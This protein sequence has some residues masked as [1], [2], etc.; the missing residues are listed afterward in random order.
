MHVQVVLGLCNRLRVMFS[1]LMRYPP[2]LTVTWIKDR[3]CDAH[4]QDLF[5]YGSLKNIVIFDELPGYEKRVD[6]RTFEKHPQI[7]WK[8]VGNALK[9]H[10][11]PIPSLQQ[12]ISNQLQTM[13]PDF[14]A[15]HIRRT[16]HVALARE[17]D[18]F[19]EDDVFLQFLDKQ[20]GNIWCAT[21]NEETCKLLFARY[22]QR[23]RYLHHSEGRFGPLQDAVV[24]MY[25][26]INAS[27]FQGTKFSSFSRCIKEMR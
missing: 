16:D 24:D 6:V 12:R 15:V 13:G 18:K 2:P 4:F 20:N 25:L 3:D 14:V 1:Y 22:G 9:L 27:E 7:T 26:C 17:H 11:R 21:D 19:T 23:V 5:E 10:L 8:E